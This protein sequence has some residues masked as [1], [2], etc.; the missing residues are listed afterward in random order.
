MNIN[1]ISKSNPSRSSDGFTDQSDN[2]C[3][4]NMNEES[5]VFKDPVFEHAILE[6]MGLPSGTPLF[7]STL[8]N[9]QKLDV[10]SWF[11][12]DMAEITY[13]TNLEELL[14]YN[15]P[16]TKLDLS[17]CKSL[18]KLDCHEVNFSTGLDV[19]TCT[20]LEWFRCSNNSL[21]NLDLSFCT[22]LKYLACENNALTVL[23]VSGCIALEHLSCDF[24]NIT[25][26]NISGCPHLD[27]LSC[28]YLRLSNLDISNCF[29]LKYLDC[30]NY[31]LKSLDLSNCHSLQTLICHSCP[32]ESLDVSAC[33][34]LTTFNCQSCNMKSIDVS[35]CRALQ[36]LNCSYNL[37]KSLD[38][39]NLLK[40]TSLR[41]FQN[42]LSSK[43]AIIGLDELRL[44]H[45]E[46]SPQR[47]NYPDKI[48]V[49]SL[50]SKTVY[51]PGETLDLTGLIVT[52]IF[53]DE[54]SKPVTIYKANPENGAV[55]SA[56]TAVILTY[57]YTEIPHIQVILF[58]AFPITVS[59]ANKQPEAIIIESMP[60]I[61]RYAICARLNLD[62]LCIKLIYSDGTSEILDK[63]QYRTD[64]PHFSILSQPGRIPISVEYKK[65]WGK[66]FYSCF[67][68]EVMP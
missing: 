22:E 12:K 68:V 55:L 31:T 26:L 2:K 63:S 46:F 38:I 34:F 58:T 41:C 44:T 24:N 15:I 54:S 16:I 20:H 43:E 37:L 10:S 9:I 47:T 45:F 48:V 19:S 51:E 6:D 14:C 50:P 3:C 36:T 4:S 35:S 33:V 61:T 25:D 18:I 66:T 1:K 23:D 52:A 64:P 29:A 62:G 27:W 11:I 42:Y 32:F 30:S 53:D 28:S 40:L 60:N 5:I 59:I 65:D 17:N 49:T 21:N 39:T 8:A 57:I 7:P 13:F 56:E 67:C